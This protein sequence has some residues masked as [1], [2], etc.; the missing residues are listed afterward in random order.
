MARAEVIAAQIG[1]LKELLEIVAALRAIAAVQMQQSQRSLDAIRDYAT[2]I[3]RAL[4][5]AATLVPEESSGSATDGVQRPGLVVFCSE[6]GFCGAF[7]E[8][9][10]SAAADA[11]A[12]R[13]ESPPDLRRKSRGAALLRARAFA[14]I[15]TSDGD[16]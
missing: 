12:E 15:D 10:I 4:A 2:I 9:L 3:R 5:E 1:S 6:H 14:R 11:C 16:P 7:N 13:A 8:P